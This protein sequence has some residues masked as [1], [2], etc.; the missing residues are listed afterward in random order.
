MPGAGLNHLGI[1]DSPN[2]GKTFEEYLLELFEGDLVQT[3]G[4][5]TPIV[6]D[7]TMRN[8][9]KIQAI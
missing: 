2:L 1:I 3:G 6:S 7:L 5:F 4:M 8:I 9:E